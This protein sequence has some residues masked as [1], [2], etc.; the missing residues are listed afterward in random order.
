MLQTV[1]LHNKRPKRA[2]ASSPGVIA[3]ALRVHQWTKN[4]LVFLPLV[5][6]GLALNPEAWI[7][8]AIGFIALSLTCSSTYLI[9]D[10]ADLKH[11]REHRSKRH[12]PLASGELGTGHAIVM[13]AVC[14]VFGTLLSAY[15][16][17]AA[18]AVLS[19]Y[20]A[21]T[22]AYTFA[23]KKIPLLDVF[24]IAL[25]FTLRLVLGIVIVGVAL[26][27]WLLLFSMFSFL[28]LALAKR[29]TEIQATKHSTTAG[30]GYLAIDAPL[31]LALGTAAFLGA[32]LILILY[33]IEDAFPQTFYLH[34]Q[35]LWGLPGILFIFFSRIWLAA[36]RGV[37]HDD[38]V[39]FAIKDSAS[40][41][42]GAAALLT[43]VIALT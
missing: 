31:V 36:Q 32:V 11:D 2:P 28:S 15:L 10:L 8:S 40:I 30:R 16:G 34:P 43:V 5:L 42:C 26:S 41:A 17:A 38:P 27:P 3:R 39:F 37:L 33:L 19:G 14:M 21:L 23:L 6:G 25:L 20:V 4:L 12:R 22:L 18:L 29:Y 35:Y 7:A 1:E 13:A 9:N 24:V